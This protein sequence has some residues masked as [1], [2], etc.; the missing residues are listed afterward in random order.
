MTTLFRDVFYLDVEAEKT[1]RGDI[2]VEGDRI[3][4]LSGPRTLPAAD[5]TIDGNGRVALLPAFVNCHTHAA[6]TLLRGL[7]EEKPLMDWLKE[8]IWPLEAHLTPD[9][10]YWGT[11]SAMIEMVSCGVGCFAD[12]Y[13]E[14]SEVA[15]AS[16]EVGMRCG[17]CRGIVTDDRKRLDENLSLYDRWHGRNGRVTVQLG[18]HAPYTVPFEYLKE[19]TAIAR[20]RGIHVQMHF[21]ETKWELEYIANDLGMSPMEYLEESG[22]LDVPGAILAHCVWL[23][24]EIAEKLPRSVTIVHNPKSNLKLGSGLFPWRDF[25]VRGVQV[26]LGTDGAASNNRLDMLDEARF[27]SLVHKGRTLDPTEARAW[28]V[29]RA[30]TL[31]GYRAL[32]FEKTGLIREGWTADFAMFDI[33]SPRYVG[34]DESNLAEFLVYSGSSRDVTGTMVD[35]KW[36][37]R[38]GAFSVDAGNALERAKEIRRSLIRRATE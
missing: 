15:R 8:R 2:L 34:V 13:F 24:P 20:E 23:P 33:D 14:M 18:P 36:P 11:M 4:S 10:I 26:A 6:M 28:D 32:G 27:A 7:G 37:Y 25:R 3:R 19:I 5:E 29:L 1:A 22:I 30:A 21:L 9:D 38:N 35:G 17:L 12:M 31:A 16:Q